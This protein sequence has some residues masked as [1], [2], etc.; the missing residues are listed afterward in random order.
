MAKPRDAGSGEGLKARAER[1][2]V[3][4]VS[5]IV[6][7]SFIAGLAAFQGLLQY[8]DQDRVRAGTYLLKSAVE[9]DYMLRSDVVAGY[10]P[11]NAVPL[12][13]C[14][15]PGARPYIVDSATVF[16][17]PELRN[18]RL[19]VDMRITYTLRALRDIHPD[20]QHFIEE[21]TYRYASD[22]EPWFGNERMVRQDGNKYHVRIAM[23]QGDVRTVTTGA[24]FFY[25]WPLKP[26]AFFGDLMTFAA[27]EYVTMYPNADVEHI[28]ELNILAWS[29][30]LELRPMDSGAF[31]I[32]EN[33]RLKSS[34]EPT[35]VVNAEA[36]VASQR[37]VSAR[38]RNIVTKDTFALRYRL[39]PVKATSIS[40]ETVRRPSIRA[41]R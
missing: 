34:F 2:T 15:A 3:L 16:A 21:Y 6:V 7:A 40:R 18:K 25:D 32:D 10:L 39:V 38:W 22:F 23:R 29:S 26:R 30:S 12:A 4:W 5:G 41:I 11:R 13:T 37:S 31:V 20:D 8:T 27:D 24:R 28:C 35:Q 14:V 1:S 9:K 19:I 36:T 33:S 17:N